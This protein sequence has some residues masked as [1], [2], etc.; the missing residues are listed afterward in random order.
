V[1]GVDLAGYE[2]K[3]GKCWKRLPE[4]SSFHCMSLPEGLISPTRRILLQASSC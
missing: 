1:T 3:E 4:I 2:L